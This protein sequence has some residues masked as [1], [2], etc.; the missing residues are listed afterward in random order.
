MRGVEEGRAG[1][2]LFVEGIDP[3]K[4][5]GAERG[6]AVGGG[7]PVVIWPK[8]IMVWLSCKGDATGI[9]PTPNSCIP[10]V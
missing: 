5:L 3:K 8:P 10:V 4:G 1:T 7:S 9:P 6:V 2:L